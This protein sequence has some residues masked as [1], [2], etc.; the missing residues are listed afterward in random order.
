MNIDH[1]EGRK[2]YRGN[3]F[4]FLKNIKKNE[5]NKIPEIV[6]QYVN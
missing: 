1:Y 4:K 5:E 6:R 3:F 2:N